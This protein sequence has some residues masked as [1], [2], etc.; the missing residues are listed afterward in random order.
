ME[1]LDGD[2]TVI[3]V[4]IFLENG[5]FR[6]ATVLDALIICGCVINTKSLQLHQDRFT[7]RTWPTFGFSYSR[8][9][10]IVSSR[11]RT[12]LCLHFKK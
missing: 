2:L 4:K 12:Y 6:S 3:F 10:A 1:N 7:A 8:Y 9:H 11:I 5:D